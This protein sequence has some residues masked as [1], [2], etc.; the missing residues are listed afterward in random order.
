MLPAKIKLTEQMIDSIKTARIAKR[1]PAVV[2]S[3]AINRDDSYLSSLELGRLRTVSAV[4]LVAML[5]FLFG[6][7]EQ[8]AMEKAEALVA[9]ENN[10]GGYNF[11][12]QEPVFV[13][14]AVAKYAWPGVDTDNAEPELISDMLDALAGLIIDYYKKDPKEAVFVLNSFIKIMRLD[15]AFAMG[16][17]G[18][19]FSVLKTLSPE[20][21]R[22]LLADLSA[23]FKQYAAAA[24]TD[25]RM[26]NAR[27][28]E[29]T[30]ENEG[31]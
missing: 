7:S 31:T 14:E 4:D 3:R 16:M 17:M 11:G 25:E 27:A 5:R 20:Q 13:R 26:H 2:L 18:M 23:V 10:S 30:P 15:N 28:N 22:L 24:K 19:P 21:R 12:N 9:L 8:E 29:A 6:I 1:I